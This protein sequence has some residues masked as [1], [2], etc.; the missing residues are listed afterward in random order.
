MPLDAVEMLIAF[1]VK[2]RK[3]QIVVEFQ[4]S[5]ALAEIAASHRCRERRHREAASATVP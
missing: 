5:T 3:E 2:Q 4:L 1:P